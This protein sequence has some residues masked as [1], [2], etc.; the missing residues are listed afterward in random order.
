MNNFAK[1]IIS[2]TS[3]TKEIR[4]NIVK[5]SSQIY[6][7]KKKS[8]RQKKFDKKNVH[9]KKICIKK[10]SKKIKK[11]ILAIFCIWKKIRL[12]SVSFRK[13]KKKSKKN[14]KIIFANFLF[15][16]KKSVNSR[17]IHQSKDR[18]FSVWIWVIFGWNIGHT[19]CQGTQKNI[20]IFFSYKKSL[21]YTVP[22]ITEFLIFFKIRKKRFEVNTSNL[23][24][25]YFDTRP[26]YSEP[27]DLPCE[28]WGRSTPGG[29]R[30]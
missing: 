13:K 15:L 7:C 9:Q 22:K 26:W 23:C 16:K 6:F 8:L 18:T 4:E 12:D 14:L 17:L 11:L 29:P 3:N 28:D 27:G 24:L 5:K 10:F 25:T 20:S 1:Y 2:Q 30:S 19:T 21:F